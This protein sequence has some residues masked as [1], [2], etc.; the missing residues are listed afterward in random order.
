MIKDVLVIIHKPQLRARIRSILEQYKDDFHILDEVRFP[1]V[2]LEK[3]RLIN[4]DVTILDEY[5][6]LISLQE[7]LRKLEKDGYMGHILLLGESETMPDSLQYSGSLSYICKSKIDE[8]NLPLLMAKVTENYQKRVR[9]AI[10]QKIYQ[11]ILDCKTSIDFVVLNNKYG[12]T[13]RAN[14]K[15]RVIT[16]LLPEQISDGNQ[17][18]EKHLAPIKKMVKHHNEGYIF[19]NGRTVFVLLNDTPE[20]QNLVV[21]ICDYFIEVE[22]SISAFVVSKN[23][24]G[25]AEL[26]EGIKTTEKLID[27]RFFM[28]NQKVLFADEIIDR[29]KKVNP[30]V[31]ANL[32]DQ[33]RY[34]LIEK[35]PIGMSKTIKKLVI[36]E[37]G[38]CMDF[39]A[40]DEL[41]SSMHD[42]YLN[43]AETFGIDSIFT[44]DVVKGTI[45]ELHIEIRELFL[46]L[47]KALYPEIS[48]SILVC[49]AIHYIRSNFQNSINQTEVAERLSV[50]TSYLSRLF[51]TTLKISF[52]EYLTKIRLRYARD[53]LL[54][55]KKIYEVAQMSGFEN[56]KYF[57]RVFRKE[58]GMSP[59]R[60]QQHNAVR[61]FSSYENIEPSQ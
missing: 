25:F 6:V 21:Q 59:T 11:E 27:F 31:F 40:L 23:L 19:C 3:I 52:S 17:F 57:A 18:I 51:S 61:R 33:F 34:D 42:I 47:F 38:N 8:T 20:L 45:E 54:S 9:L 24:N 13:M 44:L 10:S 30:E 5:S 56:A 58:T 48:K 15:F 60:F 35:D 22:Y 12:L 1:H 4:P 26:I 49:Q 37:I 55:D 28:Y 50:T 43:H 7:M 14:Q 41:R 2:G 29:S 16:F 46:E 32:V 53:I 36:E 39:E